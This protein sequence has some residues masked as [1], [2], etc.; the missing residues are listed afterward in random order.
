MSKTRR[1]VWI[2]G[3][4]AVVVLAGL[5]G[6]AALVDNLRTQGTPVTEISEAQD[7]SATVDRVIDGDTFVTTSGIHVRILGLDAPE[8]QNGHND[9][10]GYEATGALTSFLYGTSTGDSNGKAMVYL[11]TDPSQGP[12]DKY[13]RALRYVENS[14]DKDV[15]QMMIEGGWARYYAAYPVAR[16]P[17]YAQDQKD[18]KSEDLGGWKDC[19]W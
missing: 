1:R 15:T 5:V 2:G 14:D 6:G 12:E 11:T 8:T 9:C 7:G 18:A 16:S 19:G 13:G 17:I 4:A 10:Y 3:A